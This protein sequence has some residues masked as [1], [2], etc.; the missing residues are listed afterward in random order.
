M[1]FLSKLLGI[2]LDTHNLGWA[3]LWVHCLLLEKVSICKFLLL[4]NCH[5]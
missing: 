3:H 2:D 5:T 4:S 1:K